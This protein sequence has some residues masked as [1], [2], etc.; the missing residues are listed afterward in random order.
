MPGKQDAVQAELSELISEASR[1][2]TIETI[3][4]SEMDLPS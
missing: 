1:R 3:D 4:W 2:G